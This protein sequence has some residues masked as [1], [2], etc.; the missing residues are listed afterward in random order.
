VLWR[1][2]VALL[3]LDSLSPAVLPAGNDPCVNTMETLIKLNSSPT[4]TYVL[5]RQ[6]HVPSCAD[7]GTRTGRHVRAPV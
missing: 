5:L 7:N 4:D 2:L 1:S 3:A 6:G